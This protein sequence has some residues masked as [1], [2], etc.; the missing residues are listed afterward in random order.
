[1]VNINKIFW[2]IES[3]TSFT[4]ARISLLGSIFFSGALVHLF[5][6]RMTTHVVAIASFLLLIAASGSNLFRPVVAIALPAVVIYIAYNCPAVV[7]KLAPRSDL[8]YGVYLWAFT[9]QQFFASIG[10][11]GPAHWMVN[12][13][14]SA[15]LTVGLAWLSWHFIEKPALRFK[16]KVTPVMESASAKSFVK[17]SRQ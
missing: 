10:L 8:S 13:L 6:D 16:A 3:L 4:A 5:F 15:M 1:M 2:R 17:P 12:L 11:V 7:R 9:V 14:L